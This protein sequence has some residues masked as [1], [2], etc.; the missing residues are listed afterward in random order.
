[1]ANDRNIMSM[2]WLY[3][4]CAAA[5]LLAGGCG[6]RQAPKY[7][8]L[9]KR[10]VADLFEA[11]EQGDHELALRKVERLATMRPDVELT[12]Y[13]ERELQ[14]NR[15]LIAVNDLLRHGKL[16]D[17]HAALKTAIRETGESDRLVAA[18]A[19][20]DG[21]LAIS[22]YRAAMPYDDPMTAARAVA[23]LPS[24]RLF[25]HQAYNAWQK[26]QTKHVAALVQRA[27][28]RLQQEL[29]AEIDL[30]LCRDSTRVPTPLAQYAAA[31]IDPAPVELWRQSR[32]GSLPVAATMEIEDSRW[33]DLLLYNLYMSGSK[34]QRNKIQAMIADR[35]P[36]TYCGMQLEAHA[37]FA[38]QSYTEGF[39]LLKHLFTEIPELDTA[40]ILDTLRETRPADESPVLNFTDV[41]WHIYRAD[42]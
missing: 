26:A 14:N 6:D 20:L 12:Y 42:K 32:N 22:N 17:A 8:R 27:R 37:A 25:E 39:R 7:E 33:A 5:V 34:A 35:T 30:A 10:I 4:C 24:R 3:R 1:M 23:D 11:V 2:H 38:E 31:A 9:N 15:S 29:L 19:Q 16:E 13:L 21:L 28:R 36:V 41:L 40:P 18:L